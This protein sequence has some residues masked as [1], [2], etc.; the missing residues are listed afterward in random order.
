[1]SFTYEPSSYDFW[2]IVFRCSRT[3]IPLVL[4]KWS[5]W[6]LLI[7]HSFIM[8]M[9]HLKIYD[10]EKMEEKG[11]VAHLRS[12]HIKVI[13]G[14]TCFFLV[15]Y[16]QQCYARYLDNH[17]AINNVFRSS[18]RFCFEACVHMRNGS[19]KYIDLVMRWM[20]LSLVLFFAELR[21]REPPSP[22]DWDTMIEAGLVE[23]S[24]RR[25]LESLTSGQRHL[26]V[27]HWM[28][29][30]TVTGYD[31]SSVPCKGPP[32]LKGLIDRLILFDEAQK[33]VLD[34]VRM[35]VPFQYFHLT[36]LMVIINLTLWAYGMAMTSSLFGMVM[37]ILLDFVLIGIMELANTFADPYG[38]DEVDFPLHI[39]FK[40]FSQNQDVLLHYDYAAE[41]DDFRDLLERD[42]KLRLEGSNI[43]QLLSPSGLSGEATGWCCPS[44]AKKTDTQDQQYMQLNAASNN[45]AKPSNQSM[46]NVKGLRPDRHLDA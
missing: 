7:L 39:W 26:V 10:L 46:R 45:S 23:L 43:D 24:E 41:K 40:Y 22:D 19:Q 42:N 28:A 44:R 1:M 8:M 5:F 36:N 14:M 16:T 3:V 25:F 34:L 31:N 15:F 13:S 33:V 21:S 35:P 27:V 18:H 17:R 12:D 37:Y 9:F 29:R 6:L 30:V 2:S 4:A 38:D 32:L 11:G 20:R